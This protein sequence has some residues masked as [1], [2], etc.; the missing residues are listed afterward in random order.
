MVRETQENSW[1]CNSDLVRIYFRNTFQERNALLVHLSKKRRG[2]RGHK[3]SEQRLYTVFQSAEQTLTP[4]VNQS[5][6]LKKV[7]L[8][9]KCVFFCESTGLFVRLRKVVHLREV[10]VVEV[11]ILEMCPSWRRVRLF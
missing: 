4:S 2:H 9:T 1:K 3:I 5:I 11:S 6:I 10:S 8:I 7:P